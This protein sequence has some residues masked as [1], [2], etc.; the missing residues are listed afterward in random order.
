MKKRYAALVVAAMLTL[1]LSGLANASNTISYV[2]TDLANSVAGQDLWQYTYTV[3]GD[4][5]AMGS[6]FAI[7]FENTLFVVTE[8]VQTSP[9]SDWFVETHGSYYDYNVVVYDA[10]ANGDNASLADQFTVQFVWTGDGTP[11][12]QW[13]SVY[14]IDFNVLEYGQTTAASSP[15]PVPGTVMLLGSALAVLSAVGRRKNS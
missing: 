8:Q 5:F 3:S 7:D 15:V 13:F 14:D 10:T 11:G 6:G 12:A 4:S 1:G 2:A 9:S